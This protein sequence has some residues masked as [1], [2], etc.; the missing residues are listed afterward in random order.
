M[1]LYIYDVFFLQSLICII[2]IYILLIL[3]IDKG[4]VL[5]NN[6]IFLFFF[7]W[8]NFGFFYLLVYKRGFFYF[9]D[10]VFKDIDDVLKCNV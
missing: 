5:R 6:K 10:K 4:I 3:Y 9:N 7:C 2:V 8:E 1:I